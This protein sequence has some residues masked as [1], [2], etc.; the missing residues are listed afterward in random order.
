MFADFAKGDEWLKKVN[1][2]REHLPH[3]FFKKLYKWSYDFIMTPNP[4]AFVC[5]ANQIA[6]TSTMIRK[7]LYRATSPHL[8]HRLYSRRPKNSWYFYPGTK[9]LDIEWDGKWMEWMPRVPASHPLHRLYGWEKIKNRQQF[10]GIRFRTGVE[11]NFRYYSQGVDSLQSSTLSD[12]YGD[13]E[14]PVKFCEEMRSRLMATKGTW[15]SGFTATLGQQYW[16][17]VMEKQGMPGERHAA[18][19]KRIISL[20]DC[21]KYIDGTAGEVWPTRK[22][23][24]DYIKTLDN[25]E[26]NIKRRVFGRFIPTSGLAFES[27]SYAKATIG[28]VI[29][30][31]QLDYILV[32]DPGSGGRM[33]HPTGILFLGV[34]P[35]KHLIYVL[36][37]WRGDGIVTANNFIIKQMMAMAGSSPLELLI[38]DGSAA[39]FKLDVIEALPN[40]PLLAA[41]KMRNIGFGRVNSYLDVGAIKIPETRP[42]GVAFWEKDEMTKLHEELKLTRRTENLQGRKTGHQVD[43]LTDCLRYACMHIH[44]PLD[45]LYQRAREESKRKRESIVV[46]SNVSL[47]RERSAFDPRSYLLNKDRYNSGSDFWVHNYNS[48]NDIFYE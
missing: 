37:A 3:F 6:K 13:E 48:M 2:T 17:D 14:I 5:G 32:V 11:L 18:A 31:R 39:D 1:L 41:D 42:P 34:D 10:T 19:F 26:D 40:L 46:G 45:I 8:W 4:M 30:T 23:I 35:E 29:L 12:V 15:N 16:Y 20:F 22:I 9:V 47:M 21:M 28:T 36:S 25:D 27:Y 44:L 7:V 33:G 38:Y 24:A 43:D